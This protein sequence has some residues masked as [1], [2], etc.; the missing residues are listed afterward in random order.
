MHPIPALL[1]FLLL[2]FLAP[3]AGVW[4]RP[5]DWYLTLKKPAWSPPSWVFGPAWS[6]LYTLMAVAAWG[7]W[8]HSGWAWV[9]NL[10]ALQLVLNA[11]WTPIFFGW[12]KPGLAFLVI[13]LLW[14]AISATVVAFSCMLPW[15][16]WMLVPYLAWVTFAA[17]LNFTIWRLNA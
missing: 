11:A 8:R 10:W 15:T 16:A 3:L 9:L 14:L 2:T 5:K 17:A 12:R 4:V 1:A 7:V 6:L 13:V